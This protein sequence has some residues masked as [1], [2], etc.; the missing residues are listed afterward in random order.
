MKLCFVSVN[1]PRE[2]YFVDEPSSSCG[3]TARGVSPVWGSGKIL[4]TPHRIKKVKFVAKCYKRL[5]TWTDS[6]Y[7][8]HKLRKLDIRFS[9]WNAG[10]VYRADSLMTVAEEM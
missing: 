5:R 1:G 10:S 6:F 7:K 8:R 2:T 4:T 9:I 3:H